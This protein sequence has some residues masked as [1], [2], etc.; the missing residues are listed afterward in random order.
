MTMKLLVKND[1][2]TE[3]IQQ[4]FTYTY[5]YLSI[6]FYSQEYTA[7]PYKTLRKLV[8]GN[9][10]KWVVEEPSIHLIDISHERTVAQL[11]MDFSSI[12]LYAQIL[13][14]SGAASIEILLTREWTLERQNNEAKAL[15][16]TLGFSYKQEE[17]NTRQ[18]S[19]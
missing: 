16:N 3:N 7:H 4:S 9:V 1:T 17:I 8:K 2:T 11:E 5:P 6:L 14:K 18:L 15:S 12:G 13:R 19:S 10:G